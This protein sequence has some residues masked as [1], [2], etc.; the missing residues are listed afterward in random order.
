MLIAKDQVIEELDKTVRKVR[1]LLEC[2]EAIKADI[3]EG[4][5]D[6]HEEPAPKWV[7]ITGNLYGGVEQVFGLFGLPKEVSA[8]VDALKIKDWV[9]MP[10]LKPSS[11]TTTQASS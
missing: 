2:R 6:P 5:V 3:E 4:R 9:A 10:V 8:Y 7:L 11:R 1:D